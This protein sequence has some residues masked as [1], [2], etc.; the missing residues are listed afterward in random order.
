MTGAPETTPAGTAFGFRD[1]PQG[2]TRD[3]AGSDGAAF[4]RSRYAGGGSAGARNRRA[5]E[6][7]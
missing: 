7:A 1:S 5:D 3:A 6:E 2:V 4:S